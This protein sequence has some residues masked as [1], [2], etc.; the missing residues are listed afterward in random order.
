MEELEKRVELLEAQIKQLATA[1]NSAAEQLNKD[2][3]VLDNTIDTLTT[4]IKKVDSLQSA[5]EPLQ[6][7][8]FN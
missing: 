1:F 8:K 6:H 5:L 4:Y 7:I 2:T 3:Q